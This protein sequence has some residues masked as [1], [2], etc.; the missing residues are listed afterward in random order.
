[1]PNKNYSQCRLKRK[2]KMK[3]VTTK[4]TLR[5]KTQSK[6][7]LKNSKESSNSKQIFKEFTSPQSIGKI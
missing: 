1:M 6:N 4:N 7:T 5:T 2:S 3:T